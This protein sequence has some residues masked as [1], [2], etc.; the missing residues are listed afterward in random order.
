MIPLALA[1][2]KQGKLEMNQMVLLELP[3]EAARFLLKGLAEEN[4]RLR[5]ELAKRPRPSATYRDSWTPERSALQSVRQKARWARHRA[6][7][8][9]VAVPAEEM[10]SVFNSRG[11]GHLDNWL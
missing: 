2:T 4:D 10:K 6:E 7:K 8:A 1:G 9:A 11:N 5:Q 3:D